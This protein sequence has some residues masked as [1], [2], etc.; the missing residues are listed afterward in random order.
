MIM[1]IIKWRYIQK[2]T[3][4]HLPPTRVDDSNIVTSTLAFLNSLAA[5]KPDNPAPITTTD[6]DD[7][8]ILDASLLIDV[9]DCLSCIIDV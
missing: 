7:D 3:N 1:H 6:V 2:Q 8:S 9:N 5:A 4:S